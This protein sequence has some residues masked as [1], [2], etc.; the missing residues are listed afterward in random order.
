M[1]SS[2]ADIEDR[3]GDV[4]SCRKRNGGFYR[5]TI[6]VG[7]SG[8]RAGG[9]SQRRVAESRDSAPRWGRIL[10][11][12][13]PLAFAVALVWAVASGLWSAAN[14]SMGVAPQGFAGYRL[15]ETVTGPQAVAQMSRLHG[16][17]V[18]VVDGYVAHYDGPSGGAMVYVGEAASEKDALL[19]LDQMRERIAAGNQYFTDLKPLTVNGVQAF[20]VR[21]GQ[22]SHYFWQVGK[23]VIWA[24]FD[25]LD[26]TGLTAAVQAFR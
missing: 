14:P 12:L 23:R 9:P 19:L 26:E 11:R 4:S 7:D 20:S 17:G 21:S 13:L 16:K 5:V 8:V 15:A 22:E 6:S 18:G 2:G 10:M 25:R 1:C 3:R 24:Q